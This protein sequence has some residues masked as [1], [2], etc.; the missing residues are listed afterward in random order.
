M[1]LE[2]TQNLE[3]QPVNVLD[4]VKSSNKQKHILFYPTEMKSVANI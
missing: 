2:Y 3:A 4:R 1:I